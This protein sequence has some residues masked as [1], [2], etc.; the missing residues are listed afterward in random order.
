MKY[1]CGVL[2]LALL[3]CFAAGLAGCSGDAAQEE[4]PI[5]RVKVFEISA[6]ATGQSRRISGQVKSSDRSLLAFGVAGQVL[7]TKA[8]DGDMVVQGQLLASLDAEPFELRVEEA[9]AA[10]SSTRARVIEAQT[11]YDR[12]VGLFERRAASQR[13]VDTAKANLATATGDFDQAR[14]QLK[15]AE[16]DLGKT[17]LVAPFAGRIVGITIDA[18]QEVAANEQA[19]VIQ[20]EGIREVDVLVPETLIR[21][22]D[23]GQAVQVS[24]PTLDDVVVPGYVA[25][26]GAET[27]AGNA[28]DVT[29]RL[30][31]YDGDLLAGMTANVMF[32]FAD[33]LEG[34][35]AYLIPITSIAVAAGERQTGESEPDENDR[36][37]PVYVFDPIGNKIEMRWVRIGNLRGNDIEVFEGLEPGDLIVSAGVAFM[38]DGM[39]AERW[40]PRAEA[41]E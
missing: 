24:F 33:Y 14:Q 25:E 27:G 26:I 39:Q 20:A 8:K 16:L 38:R 35:T 37:S 41:G 32:N 10:L 21:E 28:F 4:T 22:L 30:S 31:E 29:I 9:R 11:T 12:Q 36:R 34:Q 7:E 5:P 40:V 13:D 3:P 2:V 15:Q 6:T 23:Y 18:F 19:A 17:K 1:C